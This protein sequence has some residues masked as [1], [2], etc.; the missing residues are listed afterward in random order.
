MQGRT[1]AMSRENYD[2]QVE[3]VSS[4]QKA[5]SHDDL[6]VIA[7]D[8]RGPIVVSIGKREIYFGDGDDLCAS[9]NYCDSLGET[10]GK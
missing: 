3:G 5:F 9:L 10:L 1:K 8:H 7:K 4:K 6:R 2:V